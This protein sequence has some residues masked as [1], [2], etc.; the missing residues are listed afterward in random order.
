MHMI[1]SSGAF[2]NT[3]GEGPIYQGSSCCLDSRYPTTTVPLAE[4]ERELITER[5]RAGLAAARARGHAGGRPDGMTAAIIRLAVVS[6]AKLTG[7]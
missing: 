2:R 4:F 5:T 1:H 7:P 3:R 6:H